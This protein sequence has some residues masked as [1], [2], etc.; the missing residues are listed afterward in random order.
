MILVVY[1]SKSKLMKQLS[2]VLFAIILSV[3]CSKPTYSSRTSSRSKSSTTVKKPSSDVLVNFD[4]SS[5]MSSA[6]EK[7]KSTGKFIFM[8]FYTDYCPPCKVMDKEVFG[9]REFANYLNANFVN[10]KVNGGKTEG[11]NLASM[12]G[13][14]AFPTLIFAD[15]NG[16]ALMRKEGGTTISTIKYMA[17]EVMRATAM[18]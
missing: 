13:V 11:A 18:K 5:R 17:E 2:I 10:L 15:H 7:S 9:N 4:Y 8:D 16:H 3:A 12:F 1:V 6:M 14:R